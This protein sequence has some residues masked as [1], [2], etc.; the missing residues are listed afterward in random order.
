LSDPQ[1]RRRVFLLVPST[2]QRSVLVDAAGDLPSVVADIAPGRS[3]ITVVE[4]AARDM[5]L[6]GPVVDCFID[7]T[8][9]PDAD[10]IA[11][12]AELPAES[13]VPPGWM[14]ASVASVEPQ[15][16][17]GVA[18]Y[19]R[20]RL[21][22]WRG[23][24]AVPAERVAWSRPG[25]NDWM[26]D[27]LDRVVAELGLG[28][29]L[30]IEPVRRWGI[31]AVLRVD[32]S[33]GRVWCKS[34]FPPF[35]AEPALTSFLHRARPGRVP[36]VLA[37]PPGEPWMVLA[38]IVGATAEA[39]PTCTSAA[40]HALVDLQRS[41]IGEGDRLLS[42]GFGDRPLSR[43]PSALATALGRSASRDELP[44][45]AARIDR[46][47]SWLTDA[48][49]DVEALGLPHTLVHGDFHP[50]NVLC[51]DTGVVVFD[52][53]DSAVSHPLMDIAVWASWFR[54]EPAQYDSVWRVFADAWADHA[55]PTDVLAARPLLE[56]ITG[57]YH[58][59]S[60]AMVI[61]GL[62]PLRRVEA[63]SGLVDFFAQL[64][65]AVPR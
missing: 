13:V 16:P 38:D 31:S 2:D 54:D 21:D 58:V 40:I 5:G 20:T 29:V 62:E 63:R 1:H 60:Y 22:E 34:V 15:V 37:A 39:D 12:V 55:D 23:V 27:Q 41:F 7:Q 17:P 53:S 33:G 4:P 35:A 56:G 14:W 28:E 44:V 32:T 26:R 43:L 19:V 8:S 3:T 36:E 57:A 51:T 48:I 64:D 59:V 25:W 42:V 10:A 45:D 50:N 30:A 18:D 24:R 47:T 65:S 61:G 52:W 46:L 6:R 9:A 11:A 49:D